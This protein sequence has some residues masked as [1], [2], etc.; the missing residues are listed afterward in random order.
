MKKFFIRLWVVFGLLWCPTLAL[1]Q[2][3]PQTQEPLMGSEATP[4]PA[5]VTAQTSTGFGGSDGLFRILVVGDSLAGGLGAGM[6]RMVQ[7]DP[8]YEIV[9][10]FN[11]SSG[12]SRFEVYDWPSAIEKIVA[13]RSVDAIVVLVGVNDRQDIRAQNLRFAFKSPEWLKAYEANVDRLLA[14]AKA[15]GGMTFWVSIP[16]MQDASFD[17]DMRYLSNIHAARVTAVG[18]H[19]VDVRSSFLNADGSYTDRGPDETGTE[20]KL[21]SRDGITFYKQ[22][23]NRFGQLVMVEINKLVAGSAIVASADPSNVLPEKPVAAPPAAQGVTVVTETPSFGQ[24]GLDGEQ[25]TFKAEVVQSPVPAPLS[26]AQRSAIVSAAPTQNAKITA[27]PGSRAQRLFVDGTVPAA[28][29][30]RFDDF[31]VPALQ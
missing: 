31:A 27:K 19:F 14:A 13:D 18:G 8:R 1:A 2:Q 29:A 30:G 7:N 21:R 17:G 26:V 6:T 23:N 16:P 25:I 9:N 22:G 28:P 4:V 12:L 11:E 3:Q 10:R 20:R 15:A 24:D 5:V